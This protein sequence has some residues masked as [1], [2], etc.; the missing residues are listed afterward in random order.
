MPQGIQTFYANGS[1]EIDTSTY[2]PRN[3]YFVGTAN[4]AGSIAVP[5]LANSIPIVSVFP[6]QSSISPIISSNATHVIWSVPPNS[7]KFEARIT[8]ALL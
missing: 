2:L 4:S 3:F 5:N 7:S 8:V 6:D 1:L